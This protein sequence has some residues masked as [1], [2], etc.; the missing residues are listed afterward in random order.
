MLTVSHSM[1]L[2]I[3]YNESGS[4]LHKNEL[5]QLDSA[6]RVPC[7]KV[8]TL[9]NSVQQSIGIDI[10]QADYCY[11]L[12]ECDSSSKK[13]NADRQE[14]NN[15]SWISGGFELH[16]WRTLLFWHGRNI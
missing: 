14:V 6:P 1:F 15:V 3:V 8:S 11:A 4:D 7:R 16:C 10:L 9:T 2:L 5:L 12:E 13:E